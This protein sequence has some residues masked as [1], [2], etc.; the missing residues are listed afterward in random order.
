MSNVLIHIGYPK[1]G[2]TYLQTW[3]SKHPAMFYNYISVAGFYDTPG[4]SRYA[5]DPAPMHECFVLSSENLSLWQS[6]VDIVGLKTTVLYDVRAYQNKLCNTLHRIYPQAKVLII[7]RGYT[8]MFS[9]FYSEYLI[10][11]GVLSWKEL[12]QFSDFFSLTYDYTYVIGLYRKVFGNENV[13]VIPYELLREDATAFTDIIEDAM[14]I[15]QKFKFTD[16]INPSID[17]RTL[18]AY[19]RVSR[20]LYRLVKPLPYSLQRVIFGY[21]IMKLDKF[22]PHPMMKFL[23]K[24]NN[25]EVDIDGVE[26][27]YKVLQGKAE[28]LRNEELFKPFLKDYLL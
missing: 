15:K 14:G 16:V 4:L 24:Y 22:K 20:L 5:T 9:S 10:G 17:K 27:T 25:E 2:S 3:F 6:D 7:P 26:E 28:I 8:T 23:S 1:A 18:A 19:R 13:I 11:G 21:Y 12:N